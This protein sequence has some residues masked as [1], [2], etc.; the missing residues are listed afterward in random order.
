MARR[1]IFSANL[2]FFTLLRASAFR[3]MSASRL[4]EVLPWKAPRS[5]GPHMF[6][7]GQAS[8]PSTAKPSAVSKD[9]LIIHPRLEIQEVSASAVDSVWTERAKQCNSSS[10]VAA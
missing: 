9:A 3:F 8:T 2:R 5:N 1:T 6:D 4:K 10:G 7:P